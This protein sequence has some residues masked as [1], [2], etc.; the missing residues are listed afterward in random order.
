MIN[1]NVTTPAYYEPDACDLSEFTELIDQA[2]RAEDVPFA[3]SIEKNIPVYDM[4]ELGAVLE[5]DK[6][7]RQL[8]AEWAQVLGHGAGVL[9][10]KRAYIDTTV[11]DEATRIFK[12]IIIEEK[13]QGGGGGDHFA[14]SGTND[15][16][17]NSLQKLCEAAPDVFLEYFANTSLAAVC[18]A[19]LGP[20]YQMTAQVNLVYPGGEA[21]QAHRDYHLG[22]Q[23]ADVSALYPAHVHDVSPVLTLQGAIAHCDMP[24]DSGPTKLLP[25]SQAYRPGYAAWRREDFRTLFEERCVQLSLVKGDAIFFSPALFH[26]AGSN[27]SQDIHRLANLLQISS[28]FGRAMESIDREKMCRLIYPHAAKAQVEKTLDASQLSAVIAATAEGYSFPTN[29]D[30]APPIN[31]LAPETQAALFQR[32]LLEGMTD[33]EFGKLLARMNAASMT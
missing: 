24:L 3:S 30:L 9:A 5:D 26:A 14:T 8:M 13:Q 28:A 18:E 19:W 11:L 29:L 21:Q 23:S 33:D 6:T 1:V 15:R 27:S 25:F 22:F 17:W 31:G 20:N 2:T 7:R 4:L 10:L 12:Q 16:I 32:A